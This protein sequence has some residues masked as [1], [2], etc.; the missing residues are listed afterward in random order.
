MLGD[1]ENYLENERTD[2]RV[3]ARRA[4]LTSLVR[5]IS[6]RFVAAGFMPAFWSIKSFPLGNI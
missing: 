2:N 5:L 4:N 6:G 3:R 1:F